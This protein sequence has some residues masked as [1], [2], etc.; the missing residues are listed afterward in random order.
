MKICRKNGK[1]KKGTVLSV[2][3]FKKI[4]LNISGKYDIQQTANR[5]P[6]NSPICRICRQINFPNGNRRPPLI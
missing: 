5:Q 4:P 1:I 6:G 2:S 3:V